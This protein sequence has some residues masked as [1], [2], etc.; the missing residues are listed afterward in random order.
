VNIADFVIVNFGELFARGDYIN[1]P[2]FK[3]QFSTK[4]LDMIKRCKM[5]LMVV[6]ADGTLTNGLNKMAKKI[7]KVTLCN[8]LGD[9]TLFEC[10]I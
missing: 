8:N 10:A 5:G 2:K 1:I 4:L 9:D 6:V 7:T 3:H